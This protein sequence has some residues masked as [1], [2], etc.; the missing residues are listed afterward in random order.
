MR[1]AAVLLLL[2]LLAGCSRS[3]Q[4]FTPED[5]RATEKDQREDMA[6]DFARN[7]YRP[8]VSVAEVKHLLGE[9]DFDMNR[10]SLDYWIGSAMIDYIVMSIPVKTDGAAAA[11]E[12]WQTS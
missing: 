3:A 6:H 5:W 1:L 2:T 4:R 11:P 7:H 9:P 10:G 12:F 8:G